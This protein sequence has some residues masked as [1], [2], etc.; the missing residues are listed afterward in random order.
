MSARKLI[1]LLALVALIGYLGFAPIPVSPRGFVAPENPG[2]AGPF[3][4]NTALAESERLKLGVSGAEMGPEDA[5]IDSQGRVHV[6]L[7]NGDIWRLNADGTGGEVFANTGG[8][9]L[10]L[11]FDDAGTLWVADAYRGLLS[12]DQTGKVTLRCDSAD[13][14][15][16][17]YADDVDISAEGIVYFSDASTKFG[18]EANGGTFPASLL[19]M[20]E[21]GYHG[22]L[23]RYDPST[24][25]VS[26]IRKNL[27]F[28][29]GVA[30]DRAKGELYLV[31]TGANRVLSLIL[32]GPQAGKWRVLI[33]ALPGFPDNVS[34]GHGGRIWVGLVAPRN[35]M[36][37][38]TA[39]MPRLRA[40]AQRL[41]PAFRPRAASYGHLIA[42]NAQGQVL[43][44][45]Q[46]STR[47]THI[48]GALESPQGLYLT[49]LTEPAL[50]RL[51]WTPSQPA[52]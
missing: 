5:A 47:Y 15:A 22:R 13:G 48:T 14:I 6:S 23:L 28:A 3:A 1:P 18:A 43:E 25:K 2:Y 30:I 46:D 27:A 34:V 24:D 16:I 17:R 9:P 36:L 39:G 49:S 20:T 4:V 52:P 21:H 45:L 10:G 51:A 19:D 32:N 35:A 33:D 42:L 41:P 7:R 50:G 8:M 29:N 26:T 44:N 37:D 40:I 12:V 31:E 38:R 11:E